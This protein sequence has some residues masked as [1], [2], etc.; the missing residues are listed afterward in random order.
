M[1][2]G[3][4][5]ARSTHC[6]HV[7]APCLVSADIPVLLAPVCSEEGARPA[8]HRLRTLPRAQGCGQVGR[9]LGRFPG[10]RSPQ[11]AASGPRDR[12]AEGAASLPRSPSC[13]SPAGGP[14]FLCF[15]EP[16]GLVGPRGGALGTRARW[17]SLQRQRPHVPHP[18]P[19]HCAGQRVTRVRVLSK[20]LPRVPASGWPHLCCPRTVLQR[21][22][23]GHS[24]A[25][26]ASVPRTQL[27]P[28]LSPAHAAGS[29]SVPQELCCPVWAGGGAQRPAQ[30][31][32]ACSSPISTKRLAVASDLGSG[33]GQS[34]L[35]PALPVP[36]SPGRHSGSGPQ[37]APREHGCSGPR[38]G[39]LA[40][41]SALGSLAAPVPS[42]QVPWHVGDRRA[43][44]DG[45]RVLCH[46]GS[47]APQ[48][49]AAWRPLSLTPSGSCPR[50]HRPQCWPWPSPSP[51]AAPSF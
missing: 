10:G 26:S 29:V 15:V 16:R 23:L 37:V 34:R 22:A 33:W 12:S 8:I 19:A 17:A 31:C 46:Q 41:G 39:G 30:A 21:G 45:S 35:C 11:R 5:V 43:P 32:E 36:S 48:P 20:T 24:S 38:G 13:P 7:C 44:S 18:D 6:P 47:L 9:G 1:S 25:S 51:G 2:G 27:A 50:R 42:M 4:Q 49:S 14:P 40:S 28:P 3:S